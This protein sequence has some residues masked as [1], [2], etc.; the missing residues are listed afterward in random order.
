MAN[1]WL[2]KTD[3]RALTFDDL[4]DRR[5]VTWRGVSQ[6]LSLSHLKRM[7][8]GDEV[9]APAMTYWATC[10]PVLNLGGNRATDT[11]MHAGTAVKLSYNWRF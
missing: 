9:I 1:R 10:L 5:V 4:V 8:R 11:F 7:R 3:P 2:L 6:P